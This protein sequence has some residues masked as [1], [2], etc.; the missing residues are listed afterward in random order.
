MAI[1]IHEDSIGCETLGGVTGYGIAVIEMRHCAGIEGHGFLFIEA[2]SNLTALVDT[3]DGSEIPVRNSQGSV[4]S[5][6]LYAVANRKLEFKLLIG[7]DAAQA[8]G[9]VGNLIAVRFSYR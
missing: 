6:E 5:G 4:G 7:G 2:H 3:L 8:G 1:N 9:V